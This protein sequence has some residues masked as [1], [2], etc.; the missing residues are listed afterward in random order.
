MRYVGSLRI[1]W[2]RGDSRTSQYQHRVKR[3]LQT[4]RQLDHHRILPLFG[5][6]FTSFPGLPSLVSP[7]MIRGTLLHYLSI[8]DR[9]KVPLGSMVCLSRRIRDP[10]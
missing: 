3:E 1:S 7:W 4:W 2:K 6:D 8:A 5:I 10:V 9:A